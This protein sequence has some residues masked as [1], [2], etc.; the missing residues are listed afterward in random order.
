M[1]STIN[2]YLGRIHVGAMQAHK[3]LALYP[4]LSPQELSVD[5]MLLDEALAGNVIE[6][7]E[8]NQGGSVPELKVVNKSQQMILL[9]DGEELVGA[10]QNRIINTTILIA[11]NSITTIPVSCVEQGRWS[12]RSSKFFSERRVMSPRMRGM[13]AEQVNFAKKFNNSYRADQGAIW[14]EISFKAARMGAVSPTMAMADIYE[15]ERPT[16]QEYAAQF[17]TE[18]TQVGAVFLIN[19]KIVGL[20][21]F[22]KQSTFSKV[23]H[24]LIESY[25]LDAIDWIEAEKQAED[26][27][28]ES[29]DRVAAFLENVRNAPAEGTPSVA[30]GTDVRLESDPTIGFALEYEGALLHLSAFVRG[31]K[32]EQQTPYS[33]M[34]RFS[35]RRGAR[36]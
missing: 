34:E 33:R 27:G 35:R 13:K 18:E 32:A 25:A 22:G 30:L 14:D 24:K 15:K 28:Q 4:L 1:N 31:K 23:F 10:K 29:A 16:I 9:L 20:D 17:K 5:Y 12:Y 21:S 8:V 2:T 19:G 6:I 36:I 26:A 11:A 7:S 3:N